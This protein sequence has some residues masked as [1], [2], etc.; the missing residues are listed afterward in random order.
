MTFLLLG[1]ACLLSFFML[2]TSD[3]LS[4]ALNRKGW[5]R[6]LSTFILFYTQIIVTEFTLGI[7][8]LLY[9]YTLWLVNGLIMGLVLCV[10]LKVKGPSL[11]KRYFNSVKLSIKAFAHP[12]KRD[13]FVTTLYGLAAIFLLWLFFLAIIFPVLDWD[14]NAYH[15]TYAANLVQNHNIY[16]VPSSLVWINGYPKAGELIQAWTILLAHND[17]IVDLTQVPFIVLAICSLYAIGRNVGISKNNARFAASLFF[18]TPM[19]MA[20][21]ITGY[22]DV[23]LP[24]IFFA[25]LALISQKK[26]AKLD[27]LLIGICFSLI[28]GIKTSG[29]YFIVICLLPLL[30]NL[31]VKNGFR[32]KKYF[33]PM[34]LLVSPMIFGLYWYIKNLVLYGSPI[35]PF[36]F[37]AAGQTIFKGTD[38]TQFFSAIGNSMPDN[39]LLRLWYTW[40]ERGP[41]PTQFLYDHS[42]NYYGLGVIW[43]I[44]LL[45]AIPVS[46]YIAI[47]KRQYYFLG[48]L[49]LLLTLLLIYPTNFSARYTV[50]VICAG[51]IA[52]GL[53]LDNLKPVT[54]KTVKMVTVVLAILTVFTNP[55]MLRTPGEIRTQ[56]ESISSGKGTRG[57]TTTFAINMGGAYTVARQIV[58]KDEK[59]AYTTL[60]WIYPLWNSDF[61]NKVVYI[62]GS[63][64]SSWYKKVKEQGVDYI[65]ITPNMSVKENRWAKSKFENV[66]YKDNRY[67]ILKVN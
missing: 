29:L 56:L 58:R 11:F 32:L 27:F 37:K 42:S 39:M 55:I 36:G 48:I 7:A 26:Y 65:F 52:F 45:P 22:V 34:L 51:V 49:S 4:V 25:A 2:I 9:T 61:S 40:S 64:E 66:I 41:D 60:D 63:N 14:G 31:F 44:V 10:I 30:R 47:R 62:E 17:T 24:A 20:Q 54:I 18:F 43:F 35:Y 46:I 1:L 15:L 28:I 19:V 67:E 16:D 57:T 8:S 33:I 38:Y 53:L 23:M 6:F 3:I 5:Q 59:I 12:K 21:L 50:F 13:P